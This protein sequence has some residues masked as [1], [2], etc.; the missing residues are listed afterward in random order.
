MINWIS[1]RTGC[2]R[3][4]MAAQMDSAR[5]STYGGR[6]GSSGNRGNEVRLITNVCINFEKAD[7]MNGKVTGLWRSGWR[8]MLIRGGEIFERTTD[9]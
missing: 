4:G 7:S 9:L 1:V 5:K 3:R 8:K 6:R 2:G